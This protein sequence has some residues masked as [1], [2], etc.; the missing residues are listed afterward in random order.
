LEEARH[1]AQSLVAVD[2]GLARPEDAAL[3]AQMLRRYGAS[4]DLGDVG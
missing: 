3:R 2:P 4:L 1:D